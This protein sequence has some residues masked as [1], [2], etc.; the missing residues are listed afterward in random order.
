MRYSARQPPDQS[1]RNAGEQQIGIFL[2]QQR[3]APEG[4]VRWDEYVNRPQ[5]V[6]L[7]HGMHQCS[8]L[9]SKAVL[10]RS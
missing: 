2:E 5:A 6:Y 1:Q 9:A 7:K 3:K 10:D 8:K 4:G